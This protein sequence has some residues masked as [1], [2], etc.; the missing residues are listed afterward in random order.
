MAA[1]ILRLRQQA[2]P[3]PAPAPAGAA[4][5]GAVR[6][7]FWRGAS[8]RRYLHT[9]YALIECPPLPKANYILVRREADGGLT[10]LHVGCGES[11]APTLNL[12]CIRQRAAVLGANEVHVHL[13]PDSDAQR[14]LVTCDLRAGVFGELS[15]EPSRG[16]GVHA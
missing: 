14:R 10:A 12:A 1:R 13:L 9:V 5:E 8:G 11:D 7:H 3:V 4:W 15:A 16:P 6:F 2:I